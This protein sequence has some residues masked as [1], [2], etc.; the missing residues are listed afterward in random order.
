MCVMASERVSSGGFVGNRTEIAFLFHRA[1]V[2]PLS[3]PVL[4]GADGGVAKTVP[5]SAVTAASPRLANTTLRADALR[6]LIIFIVLSFVLFVF[7]CFCCLILSVSRSPR[8]VVVQDRS[9]GDRIAHGPAEGVEEL[10]GEGLVRL[11]LAV[12]GD[13]D[14]DRLAPDTRREDQGA[15]R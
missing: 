12:P 7:L 14:R 3:W 6:V 9:R 1:T 10:H 5:T 11:A 4:W 15:A 8:S 13:R 2:S